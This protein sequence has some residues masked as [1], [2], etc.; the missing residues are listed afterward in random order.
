MHASQPVYTT[1]RRECCG[2]TVIDCLITSY[3]R[4]H[5]IT[6]LRERHTGHRAPNIYLYR[7]VVSVHRRYARTNRADVRSKTM[8]EKNRRLADTLMVRVLRSVSP[9]LCISACTKNTT[10][11]RTSIACG[12]FAAHLVIPSSTARHRGHR[13]STALL[14]RYVWDMT[15]IP[16]LPSPHGPDLTG[17][18]SE[19]KRFWLSR[20]YESPLLVSTDR[21]QGKTH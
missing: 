4:V 8:V 16:V 7:S 10:L 20:G 12:I 11:T 19:T 3:S 15:Y 1:R 21:K 9:C 2:Q 17:L 6:D 13:S 14:L 5:R 18:W